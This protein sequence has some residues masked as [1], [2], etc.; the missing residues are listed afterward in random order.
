M[1]MRKGSQKSSLLSQL[2]CSGEGKVFR[3]V[4]KS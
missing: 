2:C 4:S 3:N 1:M